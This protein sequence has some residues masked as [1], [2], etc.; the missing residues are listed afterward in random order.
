MANLLSFFERS[1]L[2]A[3]DDVQRVLQ[4]PP[5]NLKVKDDGPLYIINYD[6]IRTQFS[7]KLCSEARGIILEK[8]SN[9]IVC[10]PFDKFWN[11]NKHNGGKGGK[12]DWDTAVVQEKVDGSLM[13]LYFYDE[14]CVCHSTKATTYHSKNSFFSFQFISA[15]GAWRLMAAST[16][17]RPLYTML[18]VRS[19]QL[20]VL[21]SLLL[22]NQEVKRR[23][24][25]RRRRRRHKGS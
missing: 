10:Y 7:H 2:A 20:A 16:P 24:R 6:Q 22:P 4:A 9:R 8:E 17:A 15:A 13:K 11:Y 1:K 25:R 5:Y 21:P 14:R 23:R 18:S 19:A 3:F 12:I